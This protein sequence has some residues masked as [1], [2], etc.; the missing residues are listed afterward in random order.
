M[1]MKFDPGHDLKFLYIFAL[2]PK[3]TCNGLV[4]ISSESH[5]TLGPERGELDAEMSRSIICSELT[6]TL[7]H[8]MPL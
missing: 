7:T 6:C 3:L 2:L 4:K 8:T 1:F 5:H